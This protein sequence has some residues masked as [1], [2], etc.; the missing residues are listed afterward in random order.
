M[1]T[2]DDTIV[3]ATWLSFGVAGT[4]LLLESWREWTHGHLAE[5][6]GVF[7]SLLFV[8][9]TA[10][11]LGT[12]VLAALFH[13]AHKMTRHRQNRARQ[14]RDGTPKPPTRMLWP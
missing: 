4:L 13:H 3:L 14:T 8:V 1:L 2:I 12:L 11:G 7:R 5:H 10:G 6:I 9:L